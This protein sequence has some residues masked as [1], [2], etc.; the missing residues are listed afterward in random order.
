MKN[1]N[2]IANMKTGKFVLFLSLLLTLGL[3]SSCRNEDEIGESI[4][5]TSSP[6]R[7]TFDLWLL[8]NYN[9]LYNIDFVYKYEDIE[10]SIAYNLV[11]SELEKSQLLAQIVKHVWLES[12]DEVAGDSIDFTRKYV[13]KMIFLVGSGAYDGDGS[14]V[15]GTAEGGLKVTLYNVNELQFETEY[16]NEYYFHVMHHEFAHI[17]HQTKNYDQSFKRISESFYIGGDWIYASD[18]DAQKKGFI[19]AYAQNEANEDFVEMYSMYVTHDDA[20]WNKVLTNAGEAHAATLNTKL[21]LVRT[22]FSEKWKIDIDV[23]RA[24][25]LR[26]SSEISTMNYLTF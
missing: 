12:Y 16:L 17:L 25:I 14:V 13:P 5:D 23:M 24:V 18:E 4:F 21:E 7:T 20:W 9:K 8:N 19:T 15:L 2:H 1:K 26:R 22:Y 6:N 11:P 10:S 3:L